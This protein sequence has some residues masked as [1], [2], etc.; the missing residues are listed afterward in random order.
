MFSFGSH[1]AG[2]FA[3]P[4]DFIGLRIAHAFVEIFVAHHHRCHAAT[5]E[6]LHEFNRELPVLRRLQAVSMRVEAKLGAKVFVQFVR[7]A[8]C[9]AQRATDLDLVFARCGLAEHR[10]KRHEF[11]DVD[12]LQTEFPG[13]PLRGFRRNVAE[14]FLQRVQQHERR[15]A[16]HGI[17]RDQLVD[18]GL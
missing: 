16:L 1:R 3:F 17:T 11:V 14:M 13:D 5:S 8:E 10:I 6:A 18:L 15:A 7:A 12:G 2:L 9:A 4:D